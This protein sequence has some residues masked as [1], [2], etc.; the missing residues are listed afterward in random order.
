[1]NLMTTILL[2]QDKANHMAYGAV[3]GAAAGTAVILLGHPELARFAGPA[4]GAV[5]GL[6]KEAVDA[7]FNWRATG[8]PLR[9]PHGVEL[10][11]AAAT[12]AGA[13]ATAAPFWAL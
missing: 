2:P 10:A 11:D 6:A 5:V 9:G 4:A 7:Y 13:C 3:V 1:M 8:S 12:F